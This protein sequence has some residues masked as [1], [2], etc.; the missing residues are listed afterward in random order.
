MH[1]ALISL[2]VIRGR[3]RNRL[4]RAAGCAPLRGRRQRRFGGGCFIL[5]QTPAAAIRQTANRRHGTCNAETVSEIIPIVPVPHDA[6]QRVVKARRDY[7]S[8][9]ASE[10]MED[11][12]LRYTPQRFRKWSTFRVA[13]TAFGA[14]SFLI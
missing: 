7:N 2:G 8:W 11:Y 12:A 4:C 6:P 10:T 14:A 1:L 5:V 13:N 9:V 3:P